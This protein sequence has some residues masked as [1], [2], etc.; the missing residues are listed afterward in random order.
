MQNIYNTL[1]IYAE[2][3]NIANLIEKLSDF[4]PDKNG[5]SE[6]SR[7][8]PTTRKAV[9]PQTEIQLIRKTKRAPR[10]QPKPQMRLTGR[11]LPARLP[12]PK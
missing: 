4:R 10:N 1:Y 8:T 12:I 7:T 3:E 5:W 9:N 6:V 11:S 2:E